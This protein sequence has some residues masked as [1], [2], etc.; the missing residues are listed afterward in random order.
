M[1]ERPDLSRA[2]ADQITASE[3]IFTPQRYDY[4]EHMLFDS[5][6]SGTAGFGGSAG[7]VGYI[8]F[9]IGLW[10]MLEKAGMPG[11]GALIPIYNIYLVVKLA[12]MSGLSVLLLLIPV[13]NVF[14]VLYIATRVSDAF[15][16]GLLMAI[17]GL[18]LFA[19][20]GFLV[21]G[22]DGSRYLLARSDAAA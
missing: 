15:G 13:V 5:D 14:A 12:G 9:V 22:F 1:S 7:V 3:S 18:F 11:W 17:V 16:H 6:P 4:V 19:P 10:R 21:L 20:L 8:L 2:G